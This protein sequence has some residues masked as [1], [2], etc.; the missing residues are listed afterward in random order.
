MRKTRLKA[1]VLMSGGIDSAACAYHLRSQ[2]LT[3]EGLFI[4][5]GQAAASQEAKAVSALAG[6]LDIPIRQVSL[7]GLQSSG[8]GELL[9]RNAFLIFTALFLTEGRPGL[10]ALGLHAGTAYYDCSEEFVAATSK[11]VAE[12]TDGRVSLI[13]PFVTW[14]KKDVYDYFVSAG[15]QTTSTYSCEAGTEPPCGVCASCRDREALG[16]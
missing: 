11:L 2:C 10:L 9:G 13:A 16:C 15:L 7:Q 5:Y 4:D 6:H 3:V 8:S 1:T 14:T 12:H